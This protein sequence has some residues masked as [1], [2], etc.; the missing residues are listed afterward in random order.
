MRRVP[1]AAYWIAL[2]MALVG[3]SAARAESAQQAK[4]RR[5]ILEFVGESSSAF[6]VQLDAWSDASKRIDQ[7]ELIPCNRKIAKPPET[8][9]G[10][11]S[12]RV[13]FNVLHATYFPSGGGQK[14]GHLECGAAI[15]H[16]PLSPYA[17]SAAGLALARDKLAELNGG[18][19]SGLSPYEDWR[20]EA[21]C[22]LVEPGTLYDSRTDL[23]RASS[24]KSER[25]DSDYRNAETWY[26]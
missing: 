24:H 26:T 1:K 8:P 13:C 5:A 2:S 18:K 16:P 10:A 6:G 11:E 7:I 22:K 3:A 9:P 17:Q 20:I 12:A 19:S 14:S 15:H 25:L 4:Q 23:G 21:N